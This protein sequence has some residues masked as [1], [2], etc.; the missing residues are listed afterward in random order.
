MKTTW[1]NLIFPGLLIIAILASCSQDRGKNQS[2]DIASIKQMMA[3]L[4]ASYTKKDAAA[5]CELFLE[6]ADFM[7]TNGLLSKDR[8]EIQQQVTNTFKYFPSGYIHISTLQRIRFIKPDIAIG[9]GIVM[10]VREGASENEKPLFK[11]LATCVLKKEEGQ[12]RY[13]AVR[14]IPIQSD[15]PEAAIPQNKSMYKVISP[16]FK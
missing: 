16:V 13:S 15:K 8:N 4:D 14:L 1:T 9:D 12:W 3:K 7:W 2:A 11:A 10:S 5:Y 6:D